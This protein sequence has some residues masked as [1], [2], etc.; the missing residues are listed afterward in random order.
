MCQQALDS[1]IAPL[2]KHRSL[3]AY[4]WTFF[5]F[6]FERGDNASCIIRAAADLAI[7]GCEGN[8][9]LAPF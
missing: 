8:E 4:S 3:E 1:L 2:T 6:K 5:S 7:E 9:W